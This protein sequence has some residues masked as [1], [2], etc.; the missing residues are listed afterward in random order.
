M[1]RDRTEL[2]NIRR[3]WLCEYRKIIVPAHKNRSA[4]NIACVIR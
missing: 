4:L 3:S 2:P 1:G